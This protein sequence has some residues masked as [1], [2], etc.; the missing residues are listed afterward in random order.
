MM[1]HARLQPSAPISMARMS[2]RPAVML[3]E[4]V[5]VST[6]IRPKSTSEMRSLGSRTRLVATERSPGTVGVRTN[7]AVMMSGRPV[8]AGHYIQT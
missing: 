8:D 4:P 7:C 3:S 5:N 2:S 6:M 1:P